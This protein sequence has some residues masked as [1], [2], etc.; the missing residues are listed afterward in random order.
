MNAL[1][2]WFFSPVAAKHAT[3]S[4]VTHGG[5]GAQAI[6]NMSLPASLLLLLP[7]FFFRH[8]AA[9]LQVSKDVFLAVMIHPTEYLKV[10]AATGVM[11][12]IA[13]SDRLGGHVLSSQSLLSGSLFLIA[14]IQPPPATGHADDVAD[15]Q[16]GSCLGCPGN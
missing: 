7:V 3:C 13:S 11:A 2:A 9:C 16:T 10:A 8:S 12:G 5:A 1:E 6:M 15:Q 4:P 14:P